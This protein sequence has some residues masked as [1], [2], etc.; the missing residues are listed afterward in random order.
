MLE[1][2][3]EDAFLP[4]TPR[5]LALIRNL[6]QGQMQDELSWLDEL[7]LME[8]SGVKAE[9]EALYTVTGI[10]GFSVMLADCLLSFLTYDAL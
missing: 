3:A 10:Q 5:D 9:I 8:S 2:A 6:R 1:C 7:D 4:M